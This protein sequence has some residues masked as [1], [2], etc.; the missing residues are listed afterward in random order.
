MRG[1]DVRDSGLGPALHDLVVSATIVDQGR[2]LGTVTV[3]ARD[4]L[5]ERIASYS[6][7]ALAL[8]ALAG[9][10]TWAVSA[11]VQAIV[12]RPL[13][14]MT[15]IHD[16]RAPGRARDGNVPSDTSASRIA[17]GAGTTAASATASC[18]ISTLSSSNGEIL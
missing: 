4:E 5:D 9:I 17:S 3:R 16:D 18:S 10:G 11:W 7:L 1:N 6:L 12:T 2:T 15:D 8:I 14:A 13:A